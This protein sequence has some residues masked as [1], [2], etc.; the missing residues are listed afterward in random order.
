MPA[1]RLTTWL[2]CAWPW[3]KR[4]R[5]RLRAKSQREAKRI[6]EGIDADD[7]QIGFGHGYDHNF[8]LNDDGMR[9]AARVCDPE[10]GRTMDVL[11]DMPA[12]Q[13]Y[14]GNFVGDRDAKDGADY[15]PRS[16]FALETQFFPDTPHHD[17][18]P[19]ALFGPG[20]DFVATTVYA[21]S[22]R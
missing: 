10:T 19:Q 12:V 2:P 7:E 17:N 18:F 8:N 13:F 5:P 15:E 21:F 11:T 3:R 9:F 4:T 6:G 22:A 14:A 1:H 16:S 20:H